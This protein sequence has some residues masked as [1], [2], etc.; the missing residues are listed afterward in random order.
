[1]SR[2]KSDV[3]TL[4]DAARHGY[5]FCFFPILWRN[6]H[7]LSIPR[8]GGGAVR[9]RAQEKQVP[10]TPLSFAT[11]CFYFPTSLSSI[12]L[13]CCCITPNKKKCW[14]KKSDRLC[15]HNPP[16]LHFFLSAP[17]LPVESAQREGSILSGVNR[18]RVGGAE[19]MTSL[20]CNANI[21]PSSRL[22]RSVR[23]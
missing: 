15:L 11:L 13:F 8:C 16:A 12:R 14:E 22:Q 20:G 19:R 17:S 6:T 1:M 5:V 7:S 21:L 3:F 9:V 23:K 4:Q 18:R 2:Q 10:S